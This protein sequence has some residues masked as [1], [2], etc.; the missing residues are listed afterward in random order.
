MATSQNGI[1]PLQ[2][3]ALVP[4]APLK[5]HRQERL[6]PLLPHLPYGLEI[7]RANAKL[8]RGT[9]GGGKSGGDLFVSRAIGNLAQVPL[10]HFERRHPEHIF[11]LQ[12]G[13]SESKVARI[14]RSFYKTG[15]KRK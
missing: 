6:V 9:N 8:E 13:F 1:A 5:I 7:A 2:A 10:S 3:T 4:L 15:N 12:N 11:V 14:N